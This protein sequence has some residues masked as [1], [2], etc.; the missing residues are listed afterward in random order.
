[1]ENLF[2]LFLAIKLKASWDA[3]NFTSIWPNCI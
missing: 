3:R 1:M 2:K